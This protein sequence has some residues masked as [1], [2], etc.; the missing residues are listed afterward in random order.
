MT[1]QRSLRGRLVVGSVLWAA[2]LL[3][4]AIAASTAIVFHFP[5]LR[6]F[7]HNFALI[8]FALV[9][10][11][12]GVSLVRRGL[13][14]MQQLRQKLGA[15]RDG[16]APRVEG[17]YP[18]EVQ[19]L[20]DDLNALID[21]RERAV[22]RALAKA[23][24]LAHALKTPLAVLAQEAERAKTA[25]QDDFAD[26]IGQ[27]VARMTRQVNYHMAHARAAASGSVTGSRALVAEA[28]DGICRTLRRLHADRRLHL[29][30]KVPAGLAVLCQ[31]EDLE[32]MLGNLVENACK[33]ARTTVTID[34]DQEPGR[35][36]LTVDDD[37]PGLPESMREAVLGRGVRADEAAPGSGIG[38]AIVRDLA[39][40]YGGTIQLQ[41]APL[42]GLR[43]R[44]T[45]PAA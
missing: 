38:L 19:P 12:V 22:Q 33:W 18:S 39:E 32:E 6:F 1:E 3:A 13:S 21:Q 17:A 31:R 28:A 20:V 11:V 15:V 43:A 27:Q 8:S 4:V 23:A 5:H 2:G 45:L 37:G 30:S 7:A 26:A 34:A 10:I 36:A 42:G 40:L 35:V 24:D 16:R 14:P 29:E 44:L 9:C 41:R 25:G